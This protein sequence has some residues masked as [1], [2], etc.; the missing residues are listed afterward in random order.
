MQ[1]SLT[2]LLTNA[3]AV[4]AESGFWS[5]CDHGWFMDGFSM[6]ASCRTISGQSHSSKLNLNHCLINNHGGLYG[7]AEGG[8]SGSCWSST[9]G[10]PGI[11]VDEGLPLVGSPAPAIEGTTAPAPTPWLNST[12]TKLLVTTMASSSATG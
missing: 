11:L 4:A 2:L 5:T 1:L 3:L 7:Q 8:Y 12:L 9:Q 10:G 6:V